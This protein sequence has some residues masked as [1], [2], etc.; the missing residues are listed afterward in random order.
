IGFMDSPDGV[1]VFGEKKAQ[2]L[3]AAAKK[4]KEQGEDTCIC[5]ACQAGKAILA[6]QAVIG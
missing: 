5:P 3:A 4:A 2:E 1:K 6:N